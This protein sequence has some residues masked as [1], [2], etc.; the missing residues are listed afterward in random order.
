MP[1]Q[2][3]GHQLC[4]ELT[5]GIRCI[6]AMKYLAG[7]FEEVC[8]EHVPAHR[9]SEDAAREALRSR[10]EMSIRRS[11]QSFRLSR[12]ISIDGTSYGPRRARRLATRGERYLIARAISHDPLA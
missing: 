6:R 10:Y 2:Y 4:T 1:I 9:M 12:I 11:R 7:T 8:H 3:E 5:H